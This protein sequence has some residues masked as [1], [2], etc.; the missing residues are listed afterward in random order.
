M[1]RQDKVLLQQ[2]GVLRVGVVEVQL[3]AGKQGTSIGSR[4]QPRNQA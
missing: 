2:R 1:P 4:A 3:S